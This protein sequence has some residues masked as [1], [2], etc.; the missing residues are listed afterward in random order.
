MMLR[1]STEEYTHHVTLCLARNFVASR[2]AAHQNAKRS[3]SG[4][5]YEMYLHPFLSQTIDSQ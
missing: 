4:N 3:V 5:I 1:S 2:L